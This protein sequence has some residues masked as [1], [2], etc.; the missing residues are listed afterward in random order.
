[1]SVTSRPFGTTK[2]GRA[3]TLFHLENTSGAYAEVL[4]YGAV[5]C[6]AA[7]PGRDGALRDVCLGFDSVAEYEDNDGYLGAL[8]GRCANR[9]QNARFQLGDKS[10]SLHA[11]QPPSHLHGGI[12]GFDK[13][14]WDH[15]V[16]GDTLVLWRISPDGEEHYPGNLTAEVRYT[17]TEDNALRLELRAVTDA[18]TVVNLTSHAYWNLNGHGAGDVGGHTLSVDAI[19]FTEMGPDHCPNGTIAAVVGTPFDLR[20]PRPLAQGWDADHDQIRLGGGYDHNWALRGHGLREAAVL[21]AAES[22][23]TLRLSTTQP[24]LQVYTANFLPEM[25][26]KGNADYSPRGAVALEAQAFPNAVNVPAFASVALEPG[27]E[28]RQE[29]V[30][31]FS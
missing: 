2:Q 18:A 21:H 22:G 3:V 13:Y 15:R 30:F 12:R 17:F 11:N 14:V 25:K 28:Y 10:Y 24:G 26:G 31:A 20:E 5:L 19:S 29:I 6:A 8:V 23:I 16:E 27:E 9:I 1:M 7:V 4:D